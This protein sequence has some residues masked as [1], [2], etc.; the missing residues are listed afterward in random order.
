MSQL[1]Q[2]PESPE[3]APVV[4]PPPAS[5]PVTEG[6]AFHEQVRPT[7][8]RSTAARAGIVLGSALLVAVGIV[9]AMGA[10]PSPAS[11]P[12]SGIGADPSATPAAPGA[13][14]PSGKHPSFGG[15][16]MPGMRDGFGGFGV[17]GRG[18]VTITAVNGSDVA[19]KTDDG[20]TRTVTVTSTTTI[21]KGSATIAV[22]DLKVG[23]KVAFRQDRAADGTYSVTAITV[24][25]PSIAGQISAIDGQT[26]TVTQPGGTTATIH[27]DGS[28]TYRIDGAA[29]ALSN[30]KVGSFIVAEGTQRTDGSLDAAGVRGGQFGRGGH[31]GPGDP[32]H[33]G[34]DAPSVSP[35]PSSGAS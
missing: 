21:T 34:D 30:L 4:V 12:S 25:M 16:G 1:N 13:T 2:P 27:V 11:D 29:G 33:D 5:A 18:G 6:V 26:L 8:A 9:A 22:G 19:L 24:I 15:P 28:T 20:W 35:A 3:V 17:F 14:A 10:S 23:D 31:G 7:G 32:D